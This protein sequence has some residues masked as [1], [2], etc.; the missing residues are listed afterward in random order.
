MISLDTP[1]DFKKQL[2]IEFEGEQG[3]DEGGISKEFFQLIIGEIFNPDY[4]L[5][6]IIFL[7]AFL[8]FS[9]VNDVYFVQ[10][11]LHSIPTR[12]FVGSIRCLLKMS[13]S[14]C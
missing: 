1:E 4:G 2:M 12:N 11:C 5:C 9:I 6:T 14:T 13:L 7:F 3:M 10:E 8:S